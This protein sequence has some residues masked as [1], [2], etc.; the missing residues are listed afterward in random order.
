VLDGGQ[1]HGPDQNSQKNTCLLTR[2]KEKV[3]DF[4]IEI[5]IEG[6]RFSGSYDFG[7]NIISVYFEGNHRSTQIDGAAGN[8]ESLA[9]QMLRSLVINEKAKRNR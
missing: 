5:D 7:G 6:K 4:D 2:R 9:K 1:K 8:V 3:M